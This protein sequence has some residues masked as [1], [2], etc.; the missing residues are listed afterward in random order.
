[1]TIQQFE[2]RERCF[3]WLDKLEDRIVEH[4]MQ[5]NTIDLT[6]RDVALDILYQI[7]N[8]SQL[9]SLDKL[10]YLERYTGSPDLLCPLEIMNVIIDLRS[11]I[12]DD[13]A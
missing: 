13:N 1:M 11:L 8:H 9:Q 10:S 7:N 12:G 5:V 2:I 6:L 3:A 4:D